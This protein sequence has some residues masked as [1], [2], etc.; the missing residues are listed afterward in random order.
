M[1]IGQQHLLKRIKQ[2]GTKLP[3]FL[4]IGGIRGAGKTLIAKHIAKQLEAEFVLCPSNI[5]TVRKVIET[6]YKQTRPIV[7]CFNEADKMSV[8]AKNAL[9][10]I[11]EEPPR[12]AHFILNVT[13]WQNTLP[14][15]LSRATR[16]A[17]EPYSYQDKVAYVKHKGYD[18][19]D[20]E[21]AVI[22]DLCMVPGDIDKLCQYDIKEF[23]KYVKNVIEF[24]GSV[25]GVNALQIPRKLDCK[26]DGNGWN[27]ELFL[28]ALMSEYAMQG[29]ESNDIKV[30]HKTI[31]SISV[32]SKYL[33]QLSKAGI[34]K[35]ATVDMLIMDLRK[36]EE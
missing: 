30:I 27:V 31:Q 25:S 15:L 12:K 1:I 33:A 6:A 4:I 3:R 18:V 23:Y 8:Q 11:T 5:D 2:Y 7:Y 24:I 34:N 20:F 28:Q 14:T 13:A 29:N 21:L 32:I 26:D 16:I 9:L 35:L 22:T 10:K 19:S 36:L 17:I